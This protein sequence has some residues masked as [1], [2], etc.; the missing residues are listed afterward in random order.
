A[1]L[2]PLAPP[3]NDLERGRLIVACAPAGEVGA[4][5][6]LA[7]VVDLSGAHDLRIAREGFDAAELVRTRRPDWIWLPRSDRGAA[8]ASALRAEPEFQRAY[9]VFALDAAGAAGAAGASE[10]PGVRGASSVLDIAVRGDSP[11]T[12]ELARVLDALGAAR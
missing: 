9:R 8:W 6:P 4:A 12:A 7:Q 11:Y 5:L 1:E 2:A 3:P 10:V